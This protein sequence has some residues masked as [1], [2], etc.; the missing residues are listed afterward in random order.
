MTDPGHT[1]CIKTET[2]FNSDMRSALAT[3]GYRALHIREAHITGVADLL[4]YKWLKGVQSICAWLELKVKT[5]KGSGAPRP[6]Q[7][8]FMRDHW[9]L[10]RNSFFVTLNLIDLQEPVIEIV[11]GDLEILPYGRVQVLSADP[12]DIVWA[13]VFR[14]WYL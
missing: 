1:P 6:A 10:G 5:S 11:Q 3:Q 13:N 7:V 2:E 9:R 8:E 4:V 14:D 12:N